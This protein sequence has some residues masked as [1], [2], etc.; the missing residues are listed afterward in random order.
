M[1]FYKA[2]I[3]VI[4]FFVVGCSRSFKSLVVSFAEFLE[5]RLEFFRKAFVVVCIFVEDV[6]E[7]GRIFFFKFLIVFIKAGSDFCDNAVVFATDCFKLLI[8]FLLQNVHF[9]GKSLRKIS[10]FFVKFVVDGCQAGFCVADEFCFSF[11]V[12]LSSVIC[13]L[14]E[15][16][17]QFG[18]FIIHISRNF[19]E[20]FRNF[21]G[22]KGKLLLEFF[23]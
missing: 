9:F 4:D 18:R 6:V 3:K 11:F 5:I 10:H 19:L 8:V 12:G 23:L 2:F 14:I 16:V 13:F 20:A 22:S 7:L 17:F 15:G 1:F 21:V